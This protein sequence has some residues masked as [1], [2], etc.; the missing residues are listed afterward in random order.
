ASIEQPITLYLNDFDDNGSPESIITYYYEGK[1][2]LFANKD[3]LVKKLPYLNK[4]Y[5]SYKAFAE[6]KLTDLIPS[7]KLKDAR[8]MQ[9]F[10][11][12][13]CY[14]ENTNGTFKKRSL[15]LLTQISTVNDIMVDDVNEDGFLD[16]ILV[17]NDTHINTQLGRLDASQGQLLLNNKHGFFNMENPNLEI[18]GQSE[19]IAKLKLKNKNYY[20]ISRNNDT[21]IFLS[22]NK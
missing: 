17:G 4:K 2:T 10:E 8:K 12:A 13:S 6:A 11:L 21:P 16:L 3:E 20:I 15:P 9:V 1:E 22:K 5:L 7:A 14:F 18:S 19:Q